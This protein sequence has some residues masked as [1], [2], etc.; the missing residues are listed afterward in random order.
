MNPPRILIAL[1]ACAALAPAMASAAGVSRVSEP[2]ALQRV[3]AHVPGRTLRVAEG[4]QHQW[5]GVYFEARFEGPEVFFQVGAGDVILRVLVD[6]EHVETLLKPA[7]GT[8]RIADLAPRAH[9]VRIESVT[10]SQSQA[11]LFGGFFHA[12]PTRP[13]PA[14]TR[15]RQIEFIGDSHTVGYGNTSATR[16]CST[17]DVWKTTDNARA[18]GPAI[19]RHYGADYQVN[20]ISG[21][22]VVRNYNGGPGD[23]LPVAY[24]YALLDHSARI[25]N[26][27]WRPQAIVIALGTN[28]FSTPLNAGE[29]WKTR[30]ALRS[31]YVTGYVTFLRSLRARN[32]QAFMVVWATDQP[33]GEIETSAGKVVAELRAQGDERIEFVPIRGLAMTGCHWHPSTADDEIIAGA[34]IRAIDAGVADWR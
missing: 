27:A 9:S 6:G 5:P 21:R 2:P 32:P 4:Y 7:P 25:G 30:D 29:P 14:P 17:D 15:S 1:A 18:F 19:A 22:G 12:N 13:L 3:E 23:T 10:E 20:A 28:D 33:G 11:N 31:D 8:Y 24:P 26:A 34:L 16:E